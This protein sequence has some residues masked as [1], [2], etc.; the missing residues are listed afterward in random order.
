[1]KHIDD[2]I[3][4]I[5]ITQARESKYN[6]VINEDSVRLV[7]S[8]FTK[9]SIVCRGYADFFDDE[10]KRDAEKLQWALAFSKRCINKKSQIQGGID[11]LE[12]HKYYK[13]PQIGQF[14]DWCTNTNKNYLSKEQ[15]YKR[16]YDIMR[17][18][19]PIDLPLIQIM[20]I[21]HAI[22]ESGSHFLRNNA[23]V[24]TQPVFYRN[25]EIAVRDFM[26]GKIKTIP[27]AIESKQEETAELTKQTDIAKN[28]VD[29]DNYK[30]AMEKIRGMLK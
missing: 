21:R 18:G 12:E 5:D 24:K 25:Y 20:L 9:M 30:K 6:V 17:D 16:A 2:I 28:F 10:Q 14:L 4:V 23:V 13:P 22:S 26:S 29:V 11:M 15:A 27:K 3:N 1:M 7:N 8:I 19:D